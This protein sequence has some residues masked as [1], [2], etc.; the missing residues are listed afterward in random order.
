MVDLSRLST[1]T[2]SQLQ[3]PALDS[4]AEMSTNFQSFRFVDLIVIISCFL[5]HLSILKENAP[6]A[7]HTAMSLEWSTGIFA[8]FMFSSCMAIL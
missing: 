1:G 8:L 5:I 3:I 6:S 2:S 7:F 4:L